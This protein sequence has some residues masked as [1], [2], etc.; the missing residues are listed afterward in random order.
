MDGEKKVCTKESDEH[1][2]GIACAGSDPSCFLK[3][4]SVKKYVGADNL[5]YCHQY[6]LYLNF[7]KF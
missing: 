5:I 3:K 1:N 2:R 4:N 7:R 6:I